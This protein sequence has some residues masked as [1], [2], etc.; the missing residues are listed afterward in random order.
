MSASVDGTIRVWEPAT[1]ACS[2]LLSLDSEPS[3]LTMHEPKNVL[4]T[5]EHMLHPHFAPFNA[6][7]VKVKVVS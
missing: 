4:I 6:L 5:G 1:M 2:Q 3:A 7:V